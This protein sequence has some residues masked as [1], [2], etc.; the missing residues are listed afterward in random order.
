MSHNYI[1][2]S[3]VRSL[4]NRNAEDEVYEG[5]RMR[6]LEEYVDDM[7]DTINNDLD[8]Q[9]PQDREGEDYDWRDE[10]RQEVVNTEPTTEQDF[11]DY[12]GDYLT[13]V[14]YVRFIMEMEKEVKNYYEQ[15]GLE[16]D[17]SVVGDIGKLYGMWVYAITDEVEFQ[18]EYTGDDSDEGETDNED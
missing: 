8:N 4:R 6:R 1:V 15:T 7:E 16:V 17:M 9:D 2:S 18:I 14:Q 11:M 5:L 10:A 13:G 12:I 3:N